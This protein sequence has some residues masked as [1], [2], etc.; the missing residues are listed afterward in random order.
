MADDFD[1]LDQLED[2]FA[3]EEIDKTDNGLRRL[4]QDAELLV[5]LPGAE[6]ARRRGEQ[7]R[8]RHRAGAVALVTAA[9]VGVGWWQV[10]PWP[11][12]DPDRSGPAAALSSAPPVEEGYTVMLEGELL[13]AEDLPM[14]SRRQWTVAP[15]AGASAKISQDCPVGAPTTEPLARAERTYT[16]VEGA[17]A[18]Y[19]LYAF[20]D[21]DAAKLATGAM[22][23][24]LK[25]KCGGRR[26][27]GKDAGK[28]NVPFGVD[29]DFYNEIHGAGSPSGPASGTSAWLD[30]D[31]SYTALLFVSAPPEVPAQYGDSSS[32]VGHLQS[33]IAAS[34]RRLHSSAS[35]PVDGRAPVDS[36]SR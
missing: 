11:G 32:A 7:R 25:A 1:G 21:E 26:P 9:A 14:F 33:C 16:A 36:D 10:L 19:Y 34:L 31:G 22:D 35:A 17:V 24:Q 28:G 18:R 29:G 2:V 12:T 3:M 20:A 27:V 6:T 8:V 4:V 30:R 15:S 23:E 13:P 5:V